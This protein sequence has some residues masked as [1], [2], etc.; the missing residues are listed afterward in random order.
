MRNFL[1]CI[2]HEMLLEWPNRILNTGHAYATMQDTMQIT[3]LGKKGIYLNAL[4]IYHIYKANRDNL[5]MNDTHIETHNPIYL[6]HYTEYTHN[7]IYTP[8]IPPL[9]SPK[10]HS[11]NTETN[12]QHTHNIHTH[13][14]EWT[15][16]C[17]G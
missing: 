16:R 17:A 3:T 2:F 11:I 9:H 15:D 6:K 12:T 5:S 14:G 8:P 1:F 13:S 7:R 4:E 10:T